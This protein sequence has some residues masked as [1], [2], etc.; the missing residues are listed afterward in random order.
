VKPIRIADQPKLGLLRTIRITV[1]GVRYR[2][3][4]ATV[5]VAVIAMAVAFLMN[6]MSESLVKRSVARDTPQR[7]ADMRLV[8]DWTARLTKEGTL[9]QIVTELAAMAPD[10]PRAAEAAAMGR[11]TPREMAALL[12]DARAVRHTLGF[13]EELGYARRRSLVHSDTGIAILGRLGREDGWDRFTAALDSMQSIRKPDLPALKEFLRD[14]WPKVLDGARRIRQGRVE[15][16]AKVTAARGGRSILDALAEAG[17]TFGGAVRKAGFAFDATAV[18]PEV[19]DQARRI[20]Q[21]RRI[22]KSIRLEVT[23]QVVA[24]YHNVLPG[25]VTVGMLWDLVGSR[26]GAER[27]LRR[28]KEVKKDRI[29]VS[30]LTAEWLVT[31]AKL[32]NDEVALIKAKRLTADVGTGWMGLGERMGWLLMV[33]MLVCM[34]GISNAMLMTVTERFREIATLKCLGA[35]DGFIMV[36]FVLESCFLGVVGGLAGA[37]LGGLIGLGRMVVAFGVSVIASVPAMDLL[38]GMLIAVGLGVVLAAIAAVYPAFKA[39]RLA[40]MEAMRIE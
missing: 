24:Q 2:L 31:L 4:R 25:D 5:T 34:I 28:M 27:Y 22:E 39:A 1:D 13:F 17:G 38:T 19:A 37:A 35:L 23:R 36:M 3:F 9:E 33:S 29:D 10:G 26:R 14:R 32:K 16:I 7:L 6:I 21:T 8:Y 18:A 40:P 15:A 30:D 11:L 20:L 12:D